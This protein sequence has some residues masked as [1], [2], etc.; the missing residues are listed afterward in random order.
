[1]CGTTPGSPHQKIKNP[2][3]EHAVEGKEDNLD[4]C[5]SIS[6]GLAEGAKRKRGD[7]ERMMECPKKMNH[8]LGE[9]ATACEKAGQSLERFE[10]TITSF[11]PRIERMYWKSAAADATTP[12]DATTAATG[13]DSGS[14]GRKIPLATVNNSRAEQGA[15]P[16]GFLSE[17][18]VE[19]DSIGNEVG[20]GEREGASNKRDLSADEHYRTVRESAPSPEPRR[21]YFNQAFDLY[22]IISSSGLDE[23]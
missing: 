14:G 23:R 4:F 12:A 10:K 15:S 13:S 11:V 7:E 18:A 20:G 9:L 17:E 21:R 8:S 2:E 1:M 3:E 19:S 22:D 5:E 16:K 6:R